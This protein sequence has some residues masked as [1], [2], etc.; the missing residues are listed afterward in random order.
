MKVTL[1]ADEKG[2]LHLPSS[3][4]PGPEP[5]ASY[6]L[7]SSRSQTIISKIESVVSAENAF[8]KTVSP[9]QRVELLRE[10]LKEAATP[11]GLSDWDASRDS[12]YD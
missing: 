6:H 5:L 1:Q 2:N 9:Q 3:L 7:Q 4:L 8:L 11:A 10:W 12:I